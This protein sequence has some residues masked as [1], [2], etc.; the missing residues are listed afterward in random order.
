LLSA[1][2]SG[3]NNVLPQAA[4]QQ[5]TNSVTVVMS[6]P[7]PVSRLS[8]TRTK[9]LLRV[10]ALALGL[11]H[12][13]I[14][15]WRQ[16]MNEDGISYLDLG[17]AWWRGDWAQVANTTWSP[18]YG[19]LLGGVLKLVDPSIRS[20]FPLVQLVNFGI[21]VLA[22]AAF[23]FMWRELT[24]LCNGSAAGE[25]R[26]S[27][28]APAAWVAVG[29][30][31]FIYCSLNLNS[32]W[33]VTPDLTVAALVY[34]AAGLVIRLGRGVANGRHAALLG[35]VLGLG[36]LAKAAMFPLGLI[37]LVLLIAFGRSP[38]LRRRSA[39][40]LPLFAAIVAPWFLVVTNAVGHPTYSDVGRFAYLK[41]VNAMPW[42]QWQNAPGELSGTPA[43]PP[44][45]VHREPEVWEFAT[46]IGGTYPLG[47]DP[48][49]WSEGLEPT[50]DARQQ[51]QALASNAVFYFDLLVRMQ[52]GLLAIT[53]LLFALHAG[54]WRA[55]A[56]RD[57]LAVILL[58]SLAAFAMYAL[59]FVEARYI[60]PFVLLFWAALLANVGATGA[61]YDRRT[62]G[63]GGLVFALFLWINI[64]ALNLEG[65]SG[66]LGYRPATHEVAGGAARG[67][68]LG[69]G[70]S[71]RHT[72]IAEAIV[73]AGLAP[74]TSVGFIGY[75]YSAFWARLARLR[76]V[77]EVR[78][79]DFDEF[80]RLDAA[81]REAA[82]A[83]MQRAG[84]AAAI[85]EPVEPRAVPPG[86]QRLGDTGYLFQSL[87]TT[88]RPPE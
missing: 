27:C 23:E 19:W 76:I 48:A 82:L 25:T 20:E 64:G 18:L 46:P 6:L 42:P 74:G 49:W 88:R 3:R 72:E 47:F 4:Q 84:A 21:F 26:M 83:A 61:Q 51:F 81:S 86:W 13:G 73:A 10:L 70:A 87:A 69:D 41:H 17:D 30:S 12:T 68:T 67:R 32:L 77:T 9:W 37:C 85:S 57:P 29:Y 55:I 16:S 52:G 43:H 71:A 66:V 11:A 8:A 79:E 78:P 1:G 14:A 38:L 65:L 24:E 63:A 31:L 5:Q 28:V 60:A 80:W 50:F 34:V 15:I 40:A 7:D 59:V 39:L 56:R 33:A 45:L 44:R 35:V 53:L 22:L 62:L 36:Y 58:W 54:S 2:A 75:S